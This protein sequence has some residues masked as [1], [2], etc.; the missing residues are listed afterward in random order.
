MAAGLNTNVATSQV[1]MPGMGGAS[2]GTTPVAVDGG[3]PVSAGST[4]SG[5]N[6]TA[7]NP[8]AAPGS[9]PVSTVQGSPINV[10]ASQGQDASNSLAGDFEATY[11]QGTG[12]AITD[13]LGNLGTTNDA[14]IQ[15]TINQTN[16]AANQQYGNIQ[17]Q[18]AAGGV[19]PNSS[20]A[21]LASGDFYSQV[22]QGLQSTISGMENNQE[23]TLLS[24]LMTEGQAHGP[25]E[26][27]FQSAMDVMSP[28]TSLVGGGANALNSTSASGTGGFSEILSALGAL[29]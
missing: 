29:A 22:N 19:T 25:D 26:S 23:N 4:G 3:V 2:N 12:T 5:I 11:G 14:A 7:Q 20:T 15:A 21:A 10:S 18:E 8:Y 6:T 16:T 24:T 9:A 27:G 17:A 13:V 1:P 28:I